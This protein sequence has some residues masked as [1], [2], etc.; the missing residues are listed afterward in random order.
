MCKCGPNKPL[1]GHAFL[2]TVGGD[3]DDSVISSSLITRADTSVIVPDELEILDMKFSGD[4][5]R[6]W[7]FCWKDLQWVEQGDINAQYKNMADLGK[8]VAKAIKEHG[9]AWVFNVV[10]RLDVIK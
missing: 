1:K 9:G 4:L 2:V 10:P 7:S 5:N 6:D 8:P 3:Y